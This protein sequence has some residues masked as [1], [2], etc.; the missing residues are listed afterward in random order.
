MTKKSFYLR[1]V[2]VIAIC[3]ASFSCSSGQNKPVQPGVYRPLILEGDVVTFIPQGT[4][5]IYLKD[6][7]QL[8]TYPGSMPLVETQGVISEEFKSES[9]RDFYIEEVKVVYFEVIASSMYKITGELVSGEKIL[10]YANSSSYPSGFSFRVF[11][12]KGSIVGIPYDNIDRIEVDNT[13]T[14][15]F[16]IGRTATI[17]LR[18][19]TVFKAPES[20]VE[21]RDVRTS[22][23]I[24]FSDYKNGLQVRAATGFPTVPFSAMKKVVFTPELIDFNKLEKK[25]YPCPGTITYLDGTEKKVDFAI[26]GYYKV[27]LCIFCPNPYSFDLRNNKSSSSG[28]YMNENTI[29]EVLSIEFD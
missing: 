5:K 13:I 10:K 21:L 17:K 11:T 4:A 12:D 22:S 6:G 7:T 16:I 27:S 14:P 8:I 15:K 28:P 25:S 29:S 23:G 26:G 18:N 19:G 1:S 20:A 2:I 24:P 3:L 9:T